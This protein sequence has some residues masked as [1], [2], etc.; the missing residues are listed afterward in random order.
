MSED[1]SFKATDRQKF[2]GWLKKWQQARIPLTAS[3]FIE[4]LSPAKALSL[5]F[6]EDE[7]DIVATVSRIETAKRQLERLERKD[8]EDLP[9]VKRFLDK[10]EER[11][12]EYLYHNVTLPNFQAAKESARR[13]KNVLLGRIKEAMQTRLEVAENNHVLLASTIL[14]C[15]G[16]EKTKE[17]GEEDVEFADQCIVEL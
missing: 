1:K 8:V 7:I 12:R 13:S 11:G 14:N 5:A 6:Q 3:F 15:E 2:K 16:W 9:T 10:V 17:D 4:L